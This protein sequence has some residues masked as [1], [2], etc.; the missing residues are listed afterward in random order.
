MRHLILLIL[1][2][3]T[4]HLAQATSVD[5]AAEGLG[6][7][8]TANTGYLYHQANPAGLAMIGGNADIV[9]ILTSEYNTGNMFDVAAGRQVALPRMPYALAA[10]VYQGFR[11]DFFYN[12][13]LAAGQT[14]RV[15][16]TDTGVTVARIWRQTPGGTHRL[17]VGLRPQLVSLK[18]DYTQ[19]IYT[20]YSTQTIH[21]P[22]H[23]ALFNFDL[24][25]IHEFD[26]AWKW[27]LHLSDLLAKDVPFK[28]GTDTY[29]LRPQAN[30][31]VSW[32]GGRALWTAALDLLARP[33]YGPVAPQQTLASGIEYR[34][35]DEALLLRAGLSTSLRGSPVTCGHLGLGSHWA[36]VLVDVAYKSC[37]DDARGMAM[38]MGMRF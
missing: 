8:T 13:R 31:G 36:Y 23:A 2:L 25:L 7:A 6:G 32:R 16:R 10:H 26:Y 12:E 30:L 15:A 17:A 37:T 1:G 19:T 24:G 28:G 21:T 35:V 20:A 11:E 29:Q 9:A 5:A 18:T 22:Y 27:G 14:F 33:G 38:N 34:I 3:V 4:T